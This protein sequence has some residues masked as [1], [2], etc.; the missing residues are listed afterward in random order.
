MSMSAIQY[1][2]LSDLMAANLRQSIIVGELKPGQKITESETSEIYGVSRVVVREAMLQLLNE[3]L[4]QKEQNKYTKVVEFDGPDIEEIFELRIAIELTAARKCLGREDVIRELKK[5]ADAIDDHDVQ[6]SGIEELVVLD[7]DFHRY[8]VESSGNRR[9][10]SIWDDISSQVQLLLYRYMKG[11]E[12]RE[13]VFS[14]QDIVRA[15]RTNDRA[16]FEKELS[17]HIDDTRKTL[18]GQA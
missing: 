15:L 7:S 3:G 9:L 16:I 11:E 17:K 10:L 4:L 14:H 1:K 12:Y 18:L 2:S 8:L 5:R 6:G 13:L